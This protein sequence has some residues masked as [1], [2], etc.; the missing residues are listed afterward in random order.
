[1]CAQVVAKAAW[2]IWQVVAKAAW[3]IWQVVA[4]AAWHIWQVVAKAAWHIWQVVA[5][6]A[7]HIWQV[8]KAA[9]HIWQVVARQKQAALSS[10]QNAL[11]V[12]EDLIARKTH[13]VQSMDKDHEKK[14]AKAR[15]ETL[16]NNRQ[17]RND[18]FRSRFVSA[19]A[20]ASFENSTFRRLYVMVRT[21]AA[22]VWL[23][24]CGSDRHG[25]GSD[26]HGGVSD[27]HGCGSDRHGGGS[28]RRGGG[29]E[30]NGPDWRVF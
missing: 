24:G 20:A 7:W 1:M 27:R 16:E 25:G 11:K 30:P 10:R 21:P 5:K 12:K 17:R 18:H 28:D 2:H 15:T 14:I 22:A 29:S 19:N 13:E 8:A 23:N 26:R 9:W 4:K 3:H 6:A